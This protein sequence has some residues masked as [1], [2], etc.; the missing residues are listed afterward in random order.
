MVSLLQPFLDF[1]TAHPSLIGLLV[2]IFA[3]AESI[4]LVGAIVPGSG[5]VIALAGIAGAA[6]LNIW[7]ITLWGAVG[8]IIGDG[9]SFWIGYRYGDRL[10][11]M[12]PFRGRPAL[13]D[14]GATFFERHG[15]KSVFFARF[16]PGVRAVVP[17]AAGM[18]G[19]PVL[20]FYPANASSA[21]AWASLHILPAAGV[22]VAFTVLGNMSGRLALLAGTVLGIILVLFV[23]TRLIISRVVPLAAVA[24]EASI[25]QLG[26]RPDRFSQWLAKRLDPSQPRLA[27]IAL[28]STILALA[29]LGF[30]SVFEDLV[31]GTPLERSDTA[32]DHLVQSLRTP[33]ADAVMASI[34][35]LADT[36]V[37]AG[38][39]AVVIVWLI[40]RRAYA[41][42]A[43]VAFMMATSTL[44]IFAAKAVLQRARPIELY[45]G[46]DSF[47]FPSGHTT[48]ATVLFGIIAI[49][50]SRSLPRSVQIA[51]VTVAGVGAGVI[52][53]SRLY[54]AAHWASD[55]VGGF[56]FGIAMAAGFALV[57]EHLPAEKVG[58]LGLAVT[59]LLAFTVLGAW[60]VPRSYAHTIA[61]Y[62]QRPAPIAFDLATWRS[63]GWQRLPAS[64]IDLG[65]EIEEP[66]FLRGYCGRTPRCRDHR[67][68]GV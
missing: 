50:V 61:L 52:G 27:A 16:M 1:A 40:G 45:S 46:V 19:M 15:T 7:L 22:G 5:L 18:L 53:L 14:R 59:A 28:W 37:L 49:L 54:L 39:A 4:I 36:I 35:S 10:R 58:R 64:R 9:I 47:G 32:I 57:V 21:V 55:V 33:F 38:L 2:L 20:R 60:H 12:W 67:S 8:A 68:A 66:R 23:L 51:I 34:T 48:L 26:T 31:P 56:C 6:H 43:S 25:T 41:T 30:L 13:L 63:E 42:A 11:T 44:F 24:Y 3:A 65:G 29:G 17:V 62:S